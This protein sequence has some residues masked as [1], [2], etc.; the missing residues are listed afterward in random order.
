MYIVHK[1]IR[2]LKKT[3]TRLVPTNS[4]TNVKIKNNKQTKKKTKN[5]Q[6]YFYSETKGNQRKTKKENFHN[7]SMSPLLHFFLTCQTN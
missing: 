3:Q 1:K 2:E 6:K 4:C 7:D 5:Y